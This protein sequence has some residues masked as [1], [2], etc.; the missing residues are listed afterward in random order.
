[1]SL[2]QKPKHQSE[3]GNAFTAEQQNQFLMYAKTNSKYYDY[4]LFY[5]NTGCRTGEIYTIKK[6]DIDFNF[7]RVHIAGTKT[8]GSNRTIPLLEPLYELQ[9]KFD[10]K[11]DTDFVFTASEKI[12]NK[13]FKEIV[14]SIGLNE[15]EFAVYSMRH[16]FATR[17]VE[18]KIDIKTV[19]QWMSHTTI[20]TTLNKYVHITS[21]YER[22]QAEVY[23]LACGG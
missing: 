12:I 6:N 5:F 18:K 11:A 2:V 21:D 20:G 19:S 8:K 10:D 23:N 7:K 15:N 3:H 13:E 16:S 9:N 17:C 1:M 4:F 14:K 22:T